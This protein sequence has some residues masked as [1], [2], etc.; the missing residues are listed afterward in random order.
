MSYTCKSDG[1]TN[2]KDHNLFV[3][4]ENTQTPTFEGGNEFSGTITKSMMPVGVSLDCLP[5]NN[6]DMVVVDGDYIATKPDI[7]NVDQGSSNVVTCSA[8]NGESLDDEYFDCSAE[9]LAPGRYKISLTLKKS[10]TTIPD[11]VYDFTVV[12][13]VCATY[14]GPKIFS[15][16]FAFQD[17]ATPPL[18]SMAKVRLTFDPEDTSPPKFSKSI[19]QH[20]GISTEDQMKTVS[21]VIVDGCWLF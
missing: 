13:Q 11:N 2:E 21:I 15:Y 6:F 7:P 5:G 3:Y 8:K 16:D 1:K 10:L 19:Y 12:A 20:G 17:Q 4:G 18:S 14:S 9:E